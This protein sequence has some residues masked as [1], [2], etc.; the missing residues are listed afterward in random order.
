MLDDRAT[1]NPDAPNP[2]LLPRLLA[3][4]WETIEGALGTHRCR[5]HHHRQDLPCV[6][7]YPRRSYTN[8]Y[9][10]PVNTPSHNRETS[11]LSTRVLVRPHA[12]SSMALTP[13]RSLP[14]R[15]SRLAPPPVEMC[16]ILSARPAFSTAA[17]WWFKTKLNGDGRR[18]GGRDGGVSQHGVFEAG[19]GGKGGAEERVCFVLLVRV[20][21]QTAAKN[22]LGYPCRGLSR[23][24]LHT[25]SCCACQQKLASLVQVKHPPLPQSLTLYAAMEASRVQPLSSARVERPH[26]DRHHRSEHTTSKYACSSF[27]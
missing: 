18:E 21:L 9:G 16:D 25:Q 24:P 11:P 7:A 23:C 3:F 13:G 12:L 8:V 14:S 20:S 15:S 6:G 10:N 5:H 26:Q 22:D 27:S 19:C 4:P 17:T 1:K 2:P